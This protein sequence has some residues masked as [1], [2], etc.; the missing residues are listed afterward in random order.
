MRAIKER[1]QVNFQYRESGGGIAK[2]KKISLVGQ[3]QMSKH[4]SYTAV[5]IRH[6]SLIFCAH[7]TDRKAVWY[8]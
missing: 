3:D 7:A 2:I 8:A 1:E 6:R 4:T 5:W